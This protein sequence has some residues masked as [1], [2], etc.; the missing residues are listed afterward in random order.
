MKV[1]V[2]QLVLV[3]AFVAS[4]SQYS[5]IGGFFGKSQ[6]IGLRAGRQA[7]INFAA[8]SFNSQQKLGYLTNAPGY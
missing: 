5:G 2:V 1:V 4:A 6:K 7:L 3:L 8:G